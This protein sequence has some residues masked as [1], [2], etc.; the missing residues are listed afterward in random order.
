MHSFFPQGEN[1]AINYDSSFSDK[2]WIFLHND[3][4]ELNV[5]KLK[6]IVYTVFDKILTCLLYT[7]RCV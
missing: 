3:N 6:Q 7:S 5:Y 4:I 2:E 1:V